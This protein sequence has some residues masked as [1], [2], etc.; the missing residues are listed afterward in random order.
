MKDGRVV[1]FTDG[2]CQCNQF[3]YLRRAGAG[4]YWGKSHPLNLSEAVA[5]DQQTNNRA[6]L[7]AVLRAVQLDNRPLEI[8]TDS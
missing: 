1:V 5:G 6:E 4:A 8:R 2:A 3:R 7:L